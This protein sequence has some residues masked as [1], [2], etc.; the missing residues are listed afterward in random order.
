MGAGSRRRVSQV[1]PGCLSSGS[2]VESQARREQP[3]PTL[4]CVGACP[5]STRLPDPRPASLFVRDAVS[6]DNKQTD[7]S[8]IRLPADQ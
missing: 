1:T 6:H 7:R 2:D 8:M 3:L 4:C 5:R